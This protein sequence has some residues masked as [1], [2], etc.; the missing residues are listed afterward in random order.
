[1]PVL[2]DALLDEQILSA[3]SAAVH[4]GEDTHLGYQ[5]TS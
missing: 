4:T 2:Q 1:M 3:V 5:D